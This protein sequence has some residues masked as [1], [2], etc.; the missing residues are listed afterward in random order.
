[1]IAVQG[2]RVLSGQDEGNR[3]APCFNRHVPRACGCVRTPQPY[4]NH[5]RNSAQTG[6]R[7]PDA[8]RLWEGAQKYNTTLQSAPLFNSDQMCELG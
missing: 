8:F 4:H 5:A 3:P 2:Q 1:V 6:S 7:G